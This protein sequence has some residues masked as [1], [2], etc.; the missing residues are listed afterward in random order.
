MKDNKDL[1]KLERRI[2]CVDGQVEDLAAL[3]DQLAEDLAELIESGAGASFE[4]VTNYAALPAAGA[5]TG[6]YFHVLNSQG[7]SWLPGSLG[8]TYYSKG[9]YYSTGTDWVFVGEV[10][11]QASQATVDAG[12]DNTQFVTAST[13]AGASK[14]STKQDNI[15]LTTS[16]TSGAATLAAGTLNIPQYQAALTNPVTGTGANGQVTFWT[17][18]NTQS[19]DNALYW[20]NTNKRLGIGTAT[21]SAITHVVGSGATTSTTA[22]L[23][24]N[25]A[26]TNL[27]QVTDSGVTTLRGPAASSTIFAFTVQNAGGTNCFRV[28]T[29]SFVE[30]PLTRTNQINPLGTVL[31]IGGTQLVLGAGFEGGS[32]TRFSVGMTYAGNGAQTF[33]S[34]LA[35]PTIQQA[36]GSTGIT[37]GLFINPTLTFAADWRAIEATGRVLLKGAGATSATTALQVQNSAASDKLLVKD[38]GSI[39]IG[40]NDSGTTQATASVTVTGSDTNIGLALLP[41]GTGALTLA[42]PDGTNSGGG[43]AR[44]PRA[45][46]LTLSRTI[47]TAVASGNGSI[48]IGNECSASG[49]NSVSVGHGA[50]STRAGSIA[51]G[52][53]IASGA[54][55][56][57]GISS[58]AMGL[59]NTASSD[60]STVIGG[61]QAIAYLFGMLTRS[62]GRFSANSDAQTSDIRYTRAITGTSQTELFIDGSSTRAI[63]SLPSGATAGRLWNAKVQIAAICTTQGNGTVTAGEAFIG[64]YAVGISRIGTTTSLIGTVQNLHTPQTSTN[65][66]T[67]VVDITADDTNEALKI[68]F[69]PPT[70]AGSTTVIRVVATVY[71]TE[72]GY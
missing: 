29:D 5:H 22:F 56:A 33:T 25:S 31:T 66:A 48:A 10:P 57:S 55:T 68:E 42:I 2:C 7:T 14:W 20:D 30:M 34:I 46:D 28:S 64:N 4:Q 36:A 63:L 17:G 67:A 15:T 1:K 19:G 41:Q 44:G 18:T 43:N 62:S 47:A 49:T 65:M 51:I 9:F 11:Y 24:Q 16:G 52:G 27:F 50:I 26:A 37:R 61:R 12:T 38:N 71:L 69:T 53:S 39:E 23:V 6:E 21:P 32:F 58:I 40:K 60:Y 72:V 8:G 59:Q 13:L 70:T 54:P 35:N 45:I 3:V